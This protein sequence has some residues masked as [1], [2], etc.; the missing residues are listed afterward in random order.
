MSFRAF[1]KVA[2]A[3]LVSTVLAGAAPS[4]ASWLYSHSSLEEPARDDAPRGFFAS[5]L[6]YILDCAGGA[7]DP[8]GVQ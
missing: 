2:I 4:Q 8:N 6:I 7:M 1:R 5:L 3:L